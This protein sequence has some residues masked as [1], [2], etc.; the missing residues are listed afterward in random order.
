MRVELDG[1]RV[2]AYYR[3]TPE[4]FPATASELSPAP[5]HLPTPERTPPVSPTRQ[6]IE[7]RVIKREQRARLVVEPVVEPAATPEA[8]Y[9]PIT[10]RVV[11]LWDRTE[12]RL[13]QVR[14]QA[15]TALAEGLP[16]PE[17]TYEGAHCLGAVA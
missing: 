16:D 13:R 11:P 15:L 3:R 17:Y 10:G 7:A 9:R 6:Q 8:E 1:L 12:E 2:P 14:L 4:P 5:V